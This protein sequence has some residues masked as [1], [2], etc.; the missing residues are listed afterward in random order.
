DLNA[1]ANRLARHLMRLGVGPE[2]RVAICIKRS[3]ET[4]VA[5]L[6]TMKAGGAYVPL[7]P[8]YPV[9][10]LAYMLEDS[11]PTVLLTHEATS[12]VLRKY[13]EGLRCVNLERD[14]WHWASQSDA[15][16]E[17]AVG[18]QS[19]NPVYVIY[20]SGSTGRPKGVVVEHQ[21]LCNLAFAQTQ[22]F[23]V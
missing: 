1:R 12:D 14:A 2:T 15:N 20:T 21:G 19:R 11:D 4:V 13:S 7:D 17:D 6:S 3:V 18:L 23:S 9:E 10:R 8:A 16:L 5:V 22:A